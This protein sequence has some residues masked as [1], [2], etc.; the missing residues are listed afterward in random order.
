M[1]RTLVTLSLAML[2]LPLVPG[3]ASAKPPPPSGGGQDRAYCAPAGAPDPAQCSS[4]GTI[5]GDPYQQRFDFD[6]TSGPLG[7][8]PTG[9]AR[10]VQSAGTAFEIERDFAVTCLQVTGNRA[11]FGGRFTFNQPSDFLQAYAFTVV[12]NTSGPD[13]ISRGTYSNQV[14]TPTD[15]NCFDITSPDQSVQGDVVVQDAT[16]TKIKPKKGCKP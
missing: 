2:A 15:P 14:P 8:N 9:S 7:E 5:N 11:S 10:I 3:L 4:T 16:C 1:R 12:D 13:L 6:A